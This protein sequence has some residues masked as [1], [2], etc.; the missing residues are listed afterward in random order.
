[1]EP[2]VKSQRP[3][4]LSHRAARAIAAP[5]LVVLLDVA[6]GRSPSRVVE[7]LLDETA[8][9]TTALLLLD[10][11]HPQ[12]SRPA[13]TAAGLASVLLDA[14][15]VPLEFFDWQFLTRGTGR[16][17][18]HSL[19]PIAACLALAGRAPSRRRRLAFATAFGFA[20]HL[21]RDM[22]T[23]GAPFFWPFTRAAIRYPYALYVAAMLVAAAAIIGRESRPGSSR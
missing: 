19:I 8:H 20:T 2:P 1:M 4:P 23:G 16:P 10:A 21:L 11:L 13:A 3:R 9:A 12:T 6:L 5:I 7:A 14:D 17:Y 18:T 22:A 15:H